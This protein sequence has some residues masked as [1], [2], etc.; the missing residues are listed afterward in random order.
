MAVETYS[1]KTDGDKYL[2]AH[3]RVREFRCKDGSDEILISTELVDMLEKL[4]SK[5]DCSINI[6]SGYRTKSHNKKIGGSTTSK[7]CKGLA[8]DIICKRDGKIVPAKEV[9]TAAQDLN[10]DGIAL[11]SATATHVD[12]RGYRWWADETKNNKKVSDFYAYWGIPY[13]EP[14]ATVKKGDKGT[15]VRWVQ[16]RLNKAGFK[17]SVD[18]SFGGATDRAIRSFQKREGL[19]VD[20][21]VGGATR[22]ALKKHA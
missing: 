10:F 18:G 13:P 16:N 17:L 6:N 19:A 9:C 21:K 4:R 11:I 5:L 8:A 15:P 2:T 7:H 22:K 12:M 3:F 1:L 14:T 20:G